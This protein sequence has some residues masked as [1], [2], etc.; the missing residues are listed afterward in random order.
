MRLFASLIVAVAVFSFGLV[1]R[2]EAHQDSQEQGELR[3]TLYRDENNDHRF[4]AG[5]RTDLPPGCSVWVLHDVSNVHVDTGVSL[6]GPGLENVARTE[7]ESDGTARF[8]LAPG[9]YS[10][11]V[12]DCFTAPPPEVGSRCVNFG[13]IGSTDLS[14]G[15]CP[16]VDGSPHMSTFHD[17]GGNPKF[18]FQIVDVRSGETTSVT[19]R[20]H[21]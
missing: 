9:R 15:C 4:D 18:Q 19:I 16:Y 8:D 14:P 1:A 7:P 5:D 2:S 11:A 10:V 6:G 17:A 20:G 12:A 21:A 13:C 3:V